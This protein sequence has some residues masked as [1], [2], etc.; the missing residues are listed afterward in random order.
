MNFPDNGTLFYLDN[1]GYALGAR[2][3]V[4]EVTWWVK[5]KGP[6]LP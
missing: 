5:F 6:H 3:A 4:V 1:V 2:M